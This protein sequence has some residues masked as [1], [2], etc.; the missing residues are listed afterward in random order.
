MS[1][2]PAPAVEV[3]RI[4]PNEQHDEQHEH[5]H[6][7]LPQSSSLT[8]R[9]YGKVSAT[10]QWMEGDG[11][12]NPSTNQHHQ[13]SHLLEVVLAMK[14]REDRYYGLD[15]FVLHGSDE[16]DNIID[17]G[18]IHPAW[19]RELVCDWIPSCVSCFE[20]TDSPE[21]A[22]SSQRMVSLAI[23]YLDRF[24]A[25]LPLQERQ[26][27]A[28]CQLS[29]LVAVHL[30]RKLVCGSRYTV[31]PF[32]TLLK[33]INTSASSSDD[34]VVS[35][36]QLAHIE[37]QMLT[38]LKF[39]L[40][41]PLACEYLHCFK[42]MMLQE[43]KQG[44]TSTLSML[45][46]LDCGYLEEQANT[47]ATMAVESGGALVPVPQ[48]VLAYTAL[49]VM[50]EYTY[51]DSGSSADD[52]D[53][54]YGTTEF[55]SCKS[56]LNDLGQTLDLRGHDIN[57]SETSSQGDS[58]C[59]H[60]R[61]VRTLLWMIVLEQPAVAEKLHGKAIPLWAPVETATTFKATVLDECCPSPH[62]VAM[63]TVHD[64]PLT[65]EF[66]ELTCAHIL[67][68]ESYIVECKARLHH[69]K[70]GDDDND[71]DKQQDQHRAASTSA[72]LV[73]P[74]DEEGE[75]H[76]QMQQLP[77]HSCIPC[78]LSLDDLSDKEDIKVFTPEQQEGGLGA[79]LVCTHSK[80]RHCAAVPQT[81]HTRR[82]RH[83]KE[84]I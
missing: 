55:K 30:A 9:P 13:H 73:R 18:M 16:H 2:A 25:T 47:L 20:L 4:S 56:F 67:W 69:T 10:N 42:S 81:R 14:E 34:K 26:E 31:L 68:W 45:A 12:S 3:T 72:T 23:S 79:G 22:A 43:K 54:G 53:D 41:P 66:P 21:H 76:L 37:T 17:D 78:I 29:A 52:N 60:I 49:A 33:V 50:M 6:D 1:A 8:P 5:A 63:L 83:G 19:R 84:E 39:T 59:D 65:Q 61:M 36:Q 70:D 24:L 74:D 27:Q 80:K 11:A 62:S 48:H 64:V 51:P 7:Q 38:N 28:T 35:P 75:L 82:R 46:P 40:H 32:Q 77:A 44:S 58:E 57:A 15:S 71:H